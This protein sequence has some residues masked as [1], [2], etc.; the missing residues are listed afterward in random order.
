MLRKLEDIT[1]YIAFLADTECDEQ[2]KV[3]LLV[4]AAQAAT[5][6]LMV[7][8]ARYRRDPNFCFNKEHKSTPIF[9]HRGNM[10]ATFGS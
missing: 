1:N 6:F 3:W 10:S 5:Y 9:W 7:Y 4:H 8:D 2:H